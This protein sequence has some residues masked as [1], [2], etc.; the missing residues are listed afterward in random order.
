MTGGI[1]EIQN[2]TIPF[3]ETSHESYCCKKMVSH[4]FRHFIIQVYNVVF[5][6]AFWHR[7]ADLFFFCNLLILINIVRRHNCKMPFTFRKFTFK[8][9][10]FDR[11]LFLK[12]LSLLFNGKPAIR[13]RC[14]LNFVTFM[15][16]IKLRLENIDRWKRILCCRKRN[17]RSRPKENF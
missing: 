17:Y 16:V 11:I 3:F 5:R 12:L 8:D 14:K 2:N 7:V 4:C 6:E 1:K 9:V 13:I 10:I 15:N